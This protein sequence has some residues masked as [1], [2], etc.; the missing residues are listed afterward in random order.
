MCT[1]NKATKKR[2]FIN[3]TAENSRETFFIWA[4]NSSE[5]KSK[6]K[7]LIDKCY[8]DSATLQPIISGIGE[9]FLEISE[10]YMYF[11]DIFYKLNN[12]VHAMDIAFKTFF[13]LQLCYPIECQTVWLF[14]QQYFYEIPIV[15]KQKNTKLSSILNDIKIIENSP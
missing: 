7:G 9:Y 11:A 5:L 4:V 2:K 8:T 6:I 1:T 14:I 15:D 10:V 3:F 13:S 12:I